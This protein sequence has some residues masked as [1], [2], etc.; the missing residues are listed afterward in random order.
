MEDGRS[1]KIIPMSVIQF[2]YSNIYDMNLAKWSDANWQYENELQGKQY[3]SDLQKKWQTHEGLV[4]GALQQYGFVFPSETIAYV[5]TDWPG[6]I[7]FS[8]PLTIPVYENLQRALVKT[9]HELIHVA[10]SYKRNI[11]LK[12]TIFAN[13]KSA[14]PDET[15]AT[16]L[17]IVVNLLQ[18]LI[19]SKILELYPL[20]EDEKQVS[21]K[22]YPGQKKAWE[23]LEKITG[24]ADIKDPVQFLTNLKLTE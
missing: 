1:R 3:A 16:Q 4:L 24:D 7:A 8:D 6:V 19:T 2:R 20:L 13:I 21:E 15:Y 22:N 11:H 14:F 10:L 23:I 12:E 18:E 17:H 9:I 5:V